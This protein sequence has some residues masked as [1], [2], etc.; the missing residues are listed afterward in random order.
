M[1]FSPKTG[2]DAQLF[3]WTAMS[4]TALLALAVLALLKKR[5]SAK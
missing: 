3:V 2:D 5:S 4:G 1:I